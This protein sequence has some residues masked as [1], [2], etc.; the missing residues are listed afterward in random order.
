MIFFVTKREKT[1]LPPGV[2]THASPGTAPATSTLPAALASKNQASSFSRPP[3]PLPQVVPSQTPSMHRSGGRH[4]AIVIPAIRHSRAPIQAKEEDRSMDS[5]QQGPPS[6]FH[7]CHAARGLGNMRHHVR[8][9]H[10]GGVT[11]SS[12]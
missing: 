3:P 6:E 5:E 7:H 8:K 12:S 2:A 11:Q 1:H 9:R 4:C 10:R